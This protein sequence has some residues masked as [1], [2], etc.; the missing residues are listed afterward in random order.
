[1]KS[2]DHLQLPV[3][4]YDEFFNHQF[5]SSGNDLVETLVPPGGA[6]LLYSLPKFLKSWI[7]LDVALGA[8]CGRPVLSHFS[9]P[10]PVRVLLVQ[11]EDRPGE[12]QQRLKRLLFSQKELRFPDPPEMLQVIPRCPLNLTDPKWLR[13]LD[14]AIAKQKT[15][16]L[17][18]DVFRRLFRGDVNTPKDTAEFLENLD[19]LRDRHGCA[20]LLVHHSNKSRKSAMQ[21]HALGS[22]NLTAWADVLVEVTNKRADGCTT[23]VDLQ[24][25]SKSTSA[26]PTTVVFDLKAIPILVA[27]NVAE[28]D[29]LSRIRA[30][31]SGEFIVKDVERI[32][33]CS[34]STAL[35]RVEEWAAKGVIEHIDTHAHGQHVYRFKAVKLIG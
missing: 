26:E 11:V 7:A 13:Q 10:K 20:S 28:S 29:D 8:A 4:N 22:I 24:I 23:M 31:L 6:T 33:G 18:L 16:L 19:S 1:M 12:V 5:Q 14:S 30:E 34:D 27:K 3:F 2:S 25:E 15:E 35:R 32:L 17:I 21:T 9:V